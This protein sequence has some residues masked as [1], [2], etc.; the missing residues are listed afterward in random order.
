DPHAIPP[1]RVGA[2]SFSRLRGLPRPTVEPPRWYC[3]RPH[4]LSCRPR[5]SREDP[6]RRRH[7]R[8]PCRQGAQ[9]ISS[10]PSSLGALLYAPPANL[11]VRPSLSLG[12][13][14]SV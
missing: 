4:R 11:D 9:R 14:L 5:C 3:D 2:E 7:K 8:R 6:A 12:V 13:L 1:V 10:D